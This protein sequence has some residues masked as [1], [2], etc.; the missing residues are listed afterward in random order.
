MDLDEDLAGEAKAA[1]LH[2][3]SDET[4]GITRRRAG[5]GFAYYR[6]DGSRITGDDERR[7]LNALAVP[8]AYR[9]VWLCPD[10]KGHIQATGRDDRGRKQYRYHDAWRAVREQTKFEHVLEFGRALPALRA[11]VLDDMARPKLDLRKVVATVVRL[12]ET[13]LIRVGNDEYARVNK[14]FG[15]TTL[16]N[17]HVDV[18]GSRLRFA[19]KGKSGLERELEIADPRIARAVRRIQDL[20]GRAVFQYVDEEGQRQKIS[21]ADVN[22]YLAE[23]TGGHFTAKDFRTWAGT[24]LAALALSEFESFDSETA[25]KRNVKAAIERVASKLGNTPAVCRRAYVHPEIIEAYLDGTLIAMLQSEIESLLKDELQGLEPEEAAVLAFL[26]KRL[27]G[28][29]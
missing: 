19:F 4:P 27:A 20:P 25:A 18:N 12:L 14:S 15:L 28:R 24:V 26:Q 10:P 7:R 1:G 6:P 2:Y 13:T 17:R 8:P 5:K 3:V 29:D 21:S 9:D 23:V 11:R 16:Q 22:A